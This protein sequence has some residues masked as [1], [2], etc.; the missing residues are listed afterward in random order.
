MPQFKVQAP[1]GK[2]I[3]VEGPEGAT[4]D[5]AI[6]FAQSQHQ[7]QAP[8]TGDELAKAAG[9][10][11][12]G[13]I[14][15][16]E[17][18]ANLLNAGIDKGESLLGVRE[19]NTPQTDYAGRLTKALGLERDPNAS[20]GQN[21]LSGAVEGVTN[22][23]S[24]LG[25]GGPVLKAAGG[26]LSGATS[27]ALG[28]AAHEVAP[29]LETPA[30]I[31]GGLG[32]GAAAG[33]AASLRGEAQGA[34]A[35]VGPQ[36][37]KDESQRLYRVLENNPLVVPPPVMN[38]LADTM[39]TYL[40]S[41]F[42]RP[43]TAPTTFRFLDELRNAPKSTD[44]G[45]IINIHEALGHVSPQVNAKDAA[46]AAELRGELRSWLQKNVP[47]ANKEL[48]GALANW[49]AYKKV[50]DVENALERAQHR[51]STTGTG[52]NVQNTMRQEIRKIRDNAKRNRGYTDAENEQIDR[53][54]SGTIVE[55]ASR[56]VGRFAPTGLHST[57]GLAFISQIASAPIAFAG[58]GAALAGKKVGDFLSRREIEKLVTMIQERAPVN[59]QQAARNQAQRTINSRNANAAILRGASVGAANVPQGDSRF[60]LDAAG[61]SYPY[62]Q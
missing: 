45:D 3:T 2:V 44:L 43:Y 51:A 24:Y 39:E 56:W 41:K 40:H 1:D 21:I 32:G 42:Y 38:N 23:I 6:A 37:I 61:N 27:E 60:M 58:A 54:I 30:R 17:T 49:S 19:Q 62:L 29:S 13:V 15:A 18:G 4:E 25:A 22:P 53:I 34:R 8:S 59:A 57:M 14:G 52:S 36:G 33:G 48:T 46:A 12:I 28:A 16:I 7:P 50:E 55:N 31:I 35:L 10:G 5:Q 11:P 47:Q 9:R 26:A 20:T